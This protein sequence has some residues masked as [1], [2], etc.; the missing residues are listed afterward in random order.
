MPC[1]STCTKNRVHNRPKNHHRKEAKDEPHEPM[2]LR[3]RSAARSP[4]ETSSP[5][6]NTED[7]YARGI[8]G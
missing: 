5:V 2:T 3:I 6:A 1:G 8:E 4:R 7:A